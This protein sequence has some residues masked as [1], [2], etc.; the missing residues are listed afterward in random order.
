VGRYWISASIIEIRVFDY[1]DNLVD[2]FADL[3]I[4][5]KVFQ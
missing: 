3:D 2:G 4:L 1:A 5:I